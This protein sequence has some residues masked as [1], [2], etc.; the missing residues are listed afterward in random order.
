[1]TFDKVAAAFVCGLLLFSIPAYS[2]TE[3][4]SIRPFK[5]QVPQAALD[6][7]RRRINATRW[8]DKETDPSQGVP[9]DRAAGARPLLGQRLRLAQGGSEA[10][11][12]SAIHHQHRRGGHPLHPRPFPS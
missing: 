8:P 1:M 5:A 11:R 12:A 7:L 2:Q 3:D 9:L 10:E 4:R 6:D